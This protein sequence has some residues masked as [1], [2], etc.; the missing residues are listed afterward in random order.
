MRW[1]LAAALT[2]FAAAPCAAAE[3]QTTTTLVRGNCSFEQAGASMPCMAVVILAPPGQPAAFSVI[4]DRTAFVII[5]RLQA[6]GGRQVLQVSAVAQGPE[7][8]AAASGWC[9]A[10]GSG[11]A[12]GEIDCDVS[13]G[14]Q[15]IRLKLT[16]GSSRPVRAGDGVR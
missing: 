1:K 4:G 13:A 16:G 9:A 2:L 5:G 15:K 10:T 14:D 12:V 7:T 11:G 8:Q 3:P 6:S